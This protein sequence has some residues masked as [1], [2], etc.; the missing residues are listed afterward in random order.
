MHSYLFGTLHD[1]RAIYGDF[2]GCL[3]LAF[4]SVCVWRDHDSLHTKLLCF[5]SFSTDRLDGLDAK[6]YHSAMFYMH[7]TPI[8][9]KLR[10]FE[11]KGT[12]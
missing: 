11:Q 8:S 10:M 4:I 9:K 2:I 1:S 12:P 7:N 6:A 5:I 3:T